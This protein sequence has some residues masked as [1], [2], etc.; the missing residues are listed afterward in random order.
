[1]SLVRLP[2]VLLSLASALHSLAVAAD[3]SKLAGAELYAKQCA[4]CHGPRG[5][6]TPD[7][8]P[9]PLFGDKSTI[10]LAETITA[11]MP[12]GEPELCVGEDAKAI[13]L[14][15][16]NAF[17]S[18]EAQARINPP[19]KKLSRLTVSQYRNC[20]ADLAQ[21]FSWSNQPDD[22][23]GLKAT[24]F[25]SRRFRDKAFERLDPVVE[26]NF[27]EGTPDPEK[28]P[29]NKEFSIR[30]E[31]SL[32]VD[33]TGWYDF[34]LDTENG[35]RLFLNNGRDA[36][37]DAYVRSGDQREY[38]A[39]IFLLSG[40]LYPLKLEWFTFQEKTAS[41]RL[42]WKPPH[43]VFETIPTRHL[44]PQKTADVLVV[45]TPFP[46]D[47]RNDGYI[48]G[49]AVSPEWHEATTFAAIE[50][51]DKLTERVQNF[52]KIKKEDDEAAR[53]EKLKSFCTTFLTRAFRRPADE[54][55]TALYVHRF[56]ADELSNEDALR[57]SLL[58]ILKSP[59]F[60]YRNVTQEN[61]LYTKAED[62]SFAMIDSLPHPELL[63]AAEKQWIAN[64][65]GLRDQA[66]RMAN[67]LRGKV[68]LKEF[69]RVWLN[70]ERFEDIDKSDEVFADFSPELVANLRASLEVSLDKAIEK[71]ERGFE[72]LLRSPDFWVNDRLAEYY[73]LPTDGLSRHSFSDV[74]FEKEHRAGVISHPFML[75]ALAYRDTS[76]PIHRGVFLSRGLLGRTLKPPPDSVSPTAPDLEP[77]LTTR[78]RVAKQTSPALC[79]TCHTMINALGFALENFDAVGRFRKEEKGKP[80]DASGNYRLRSGEFTEFHG[81]PELAEFLATS[82]ETHRSFSRQLFHFMVQQPIL[83]Y[84]PKRID[85][86]ADFFADHQFDMT[87]LMVE[88]AMI[89]ANTSD[90]PASV[91]TAQLPPT[92]DRTSK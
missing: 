63:K 47:D 9:Q 45:E 57:R 89:S 84:G 81:A 40:R 66:W 61:D 12:E 58:S 64:D 46:P 6:G 83:A 42:L 82:S 11:T 30:F 14:W 3:D 67:S 77:D 31:G 23:R 15:M 88:I 80:V 7:N 91:P 20:I 48:R 22:K 55:L 59:R 24:Y 36:L 17:Y 69:L 76:S 44:S 5:E 26:F 21:G 52:A 43:G 60:L 68:R 56:F 92:S 19:K 90:T 38:S 32:I 71:R 34:T 35:G 18:P 70:L 53:R 37:I 25:K 62:L 65:K 73:G 50:A 87:E 86:L 10:E 4:D 2:L 75:T 13:A 72:Q 78:E 74:Q 28:I 1:M 85:D 51:V 39:S 54:K 33:E 27:G 79:A 29:E 8:Y 41:V 16:Q 49:T